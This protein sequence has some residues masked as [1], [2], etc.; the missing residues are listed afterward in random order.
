MLTLNNERRDW[1]D[2]PKLFEDSMIRSQ[3]WVAM[4]CQISNWPVEVINWLLTCRLTKSY[5]RSVL[6]N[7]L[8]TV[9]LRFDWH[10]H[11]Y[12]GETVPS[13]SSTIYCFCA[14]SINR[15]LSGE[16]NHFWKHYLFRPV[17]TSILISDPTKKM[18]SVLSVGPSYVYWVFPLAATMR[19]G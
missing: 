5:H 11:S 19:G 16:T 9:L 8:I 2:W 10:W 12:H 6:M 13:L 4:D 17:V 7:R 14:S 3:L 18:T 15:R 1:Y